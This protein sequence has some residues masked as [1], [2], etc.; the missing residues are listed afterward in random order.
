MP[1]LN[2][3][4]VAH[5]KEYEA[6]VNRVASKRVLESRKEYFEQI[7]QGQKLAASGGGYGALSRLGAS[8][9]MFVS[10]ARDTLT[11][12]A[13]GAPITQVVAQQAPQ[14]LQGFAMLGLSLKAL[15]VYAIG[16]GLALATIKSGVDAY[17]AKIEEQKS[18]ANLEQTIAANRIRL[19]KLLDENEKRMKPGEAQSLKSTLWDAILKSITSSNKDYWSRYLGD[20][21]ANVRDRLRDVII[22]PEQKKNLKTIGELSTKAMIDSMERF[23]KER[24]LVNEQYR[25]AYDKITEMSKGLK[26]GGDDAVVQAAFYNIGKARDKQISDINERQAKEDELKKEVVHKARIAPDVS[27]LQRIGGMPVGDAVMIDLNKVQIAELIKIRAEI[28][29]NNRGVAF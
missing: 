16:A 21:E 4:F 6:A 26:T 24:A 23:D 2:V 5:T 29:K 10:A 25:E 11:S 20:V 9:S 14:V 22:G 3:R 19:L 1:D 27:S 17:N 18:A 28:A 13:S 15:G 7:R 8:Q 12:L